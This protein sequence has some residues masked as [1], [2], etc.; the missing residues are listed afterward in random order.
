MYPTIGSA[1]CTFWYRFGQVT[2]KPL[3]RLDIESGLVRPCSRFL[4]LLIV[5]MVS[6]WRG[7]DKLARMLDELR[8]R[9]LHAR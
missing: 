6:A 2:N 4:V 5:S 8:G 3:A 1:N 9:E 7:H